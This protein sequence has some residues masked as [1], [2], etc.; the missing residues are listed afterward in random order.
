MLAKI[1]YFNHTGITFVHKIIRVIFLNLLF[2][3]ISVNI[4]YAKLYFPNIQCGGSWDTEINIINPNTQKTLTG[5]L[6]AF[7]TDFRGNFN[8]QYL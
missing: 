1:F 6:K 3:F 7:N 8:R 4:S 5:I 2:F